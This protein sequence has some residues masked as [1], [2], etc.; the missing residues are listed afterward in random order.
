MTR[1]TPQ[2]FLSTAVTPE[3]PKSPN[4]QYFTQT[5]LANERQLT[6]KE[7]LDFLNTDNVKLFLENRH[8]T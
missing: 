8:L 4:E 2:S 1:L 5:L 7:R 3:P 6:D